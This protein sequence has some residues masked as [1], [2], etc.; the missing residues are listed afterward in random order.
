MIKN[1]ILG[2]LGLTAKAGR[3]AFGADSVEQ[4][5]KRRKDRLLLVATDASERTK[6]KFEEIAEE[7]TIPLLVTETI[8]DLSKAIGKSNKA[9]VGVKDNHLA[10]EIQ[11]IYDGGDTIG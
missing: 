11:K 1:K 9:V 5:C 4:D 6:K 8:E 10:S 7:Y 3:I 2:L